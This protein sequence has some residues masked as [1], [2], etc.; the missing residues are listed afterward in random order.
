MRFAAPLP[1][2]EEIGHT[3]EEVTASHFQWFQRGNLGHSERDQFWPTVP[4]VE[5][6]NTII[7][8]T[9]DLAFIGYSAVIVGLALLII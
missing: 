6:L 7:P 8:A 1:E 5:R 3:P 4:K 9:I 2:L